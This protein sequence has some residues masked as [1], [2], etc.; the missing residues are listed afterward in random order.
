MSSELPLLG[1]NVGE[2]LN[3]ADVEFHYMK[4]KTTIIGHLAFW[5]FY[6]TVVGTGGSLISDTSQGWPFVWNSLVFGGIVIYGNLLFILPLLLEKKYGRFALIGLGFVT[7]VILLRFETEHLFGLD[8][9][10]KFGWPAVFFMSMQILALF[11]LSTMFGGFMQWFRDRERTAFL[12]KEKLAG[13]LKFLKTQV[14]PHFLFNSLNNIYSLAYRQHPNAAPMIATLSKIM[15]YHLY[16]G[17]RERVSLEKEVEMLQDFIA[18]QRL[19][20]GDALNVDFYSEGVENQQLIA[21]LLL[22]N[23]IENS[24]KHGDADSNPE[25]FV[26]VNLTVENGRL[27]FSVENSFS[28]KAK[29]GE[30]HPDVQAEEGF[31][32]KNAQRLLDLTYPNRYELTQKAENGIYSVQLMLAI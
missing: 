6:L 23:F 27:E 14:N 12:Q 3:F 26:Q 8:L 20:Y 29:V 2:V 30:V 28:R 15:R 24:F 19:K 25:A 21:P 18:L 13:E 4:N 31:G 5:L 1:T 9:T 11:L 7:L 32:L 17:S 16:D 22:I 10:D